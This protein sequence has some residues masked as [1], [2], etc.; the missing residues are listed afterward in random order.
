ME[1]KSCLNESVAG[2]LT[3][4]WTIS[5]TDCSRFKSLFSKTF[6]ALPTNLSILSCLPQVPFLLIVQLFSVMRQYNINPYNNAFPLPNGR[7]MRSNFYLWSFC[8]SRSSHTSTQKSGPDK[9]IL[10]CLRAVGSRCSH[11]GYLSPG[12]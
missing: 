12:L 4:T 3:S 8:W 6:L 5:S 10:G 2:V 7:G 9:N 11:H 1:F